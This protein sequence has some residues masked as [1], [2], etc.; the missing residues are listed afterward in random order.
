MPEETEY[1][2]HEEKTKIHKVTFFQIFEGLH[3]GGKQVVLWGD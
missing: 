1:A 3:M 2:F